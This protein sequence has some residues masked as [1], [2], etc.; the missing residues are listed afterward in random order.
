MF[1]FLRNEV[2]LLR[3]E[4]EGVEEREKDKLVFAGQLSD[5]RECHGVLTI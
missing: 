5:N 2:W 1:Y 3:S 4:G